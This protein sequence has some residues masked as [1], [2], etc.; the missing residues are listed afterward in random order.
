ML[1][2]QIWYEWRSVGLKM[3]LIISCPSCAFLLLPLKVSGAASVWSVL[4]FA[5][6]ILL[7]ICMPAGL[8]AFAKHDTNARRGAARFAHTRCVDDSLLAWAKLGGSAATVLGS[9]VVVT[10]FAWLSYLVFVKLGLD[11][12][13][14]PIPD[15]MRP[16]F[17]KGA[18]HAT[19]ILAGMWISY[20][21]GGFVVIVAIVVALAE[22]FGARIWPAAHAYLWVTTDSM[23]TP[24][25]LNLVLLVC[26]PICLASIALPWRRNVIS[27][28][29][30][31]VLAIAWASG[32]V[33]GTAMPRWLET[34]V[35]DVSFPTF[36]AW[37]AGLTLLALTPFATTPLQ[38]HRLRH[39]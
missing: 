15:E 13:L 11:K 34:N 2:A 21:R 31:A 7:L 5:W 6:Q 19:L 14:T 10:A 20:T 4:V 16:T 35:Y 25:I 33:L 24:R 23:A 22:G 8:W 28:R 38:V 39:R 12:N 9:F 36:Y 18:A 37:V 1:C 3:T 29:T 17:A 26:A 30:P 32:T 27:W